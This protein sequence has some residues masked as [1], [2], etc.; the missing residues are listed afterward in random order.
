VK[1]NSHVNGLVLE[2]LSAGTYTCQRGKP[3]AS[4]DTVM[5][6]IANRIALRLRVEKP[7]GLPA[8]EGLRAAHP[9]AFR[10]LDALL[11]RL[12]AD[13][14]I[15]DLTGVA[16]PGKWETLRPDIS[17]KRGKDVFSVFFRGTLCNPVIDIL[18]ARAG[19]PG[20]LKPGRALVHGPARQGGAQCGESYGSAVGYLIEEHL[21]DLARDLDPSGWGRSTVPAT[22]EYVHPRP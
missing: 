3:P 18:P 19:R 6:R 13:R 2:I 10:A 22:A 21:T 11:P 1:P 12:L 7:T 15:C 8:I 20:H 17:R 5:Y 16:G 4:R 9:D 14:R